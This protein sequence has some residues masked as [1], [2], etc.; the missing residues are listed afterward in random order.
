MKRSRQIPKPSAPLPGYAPHMF[1][2]TGAIVVVFWFLGIRWFDP[3]LVAQVRALPDPLP[4]GVFVSA[5]LALLVG[6]NALFVAG[7][8]AVEELK[9]VHVRHVR[10]ENEAHATK[11]QVL[12]DHQLRFAT[13]CSLGSRTVRLCMVFLVVVLGQNIAETLHRQASHPYHYGTVLFWALVVAIPVIAINLPVGELLPASYAEM[14]PHKAGLR[15]YRFIRAA[16]A[17][18]A[19][20]A[21]ILVGFS[22]A[23]TNLLAKRSDVESVI[24]P[25]EEIRTIVESAEETGDIASEER[26]LIHS[27]FEFKDTIVREIMTPRVDLD[28]VA[29]QT[30]PRAIV[31]LISE[32][33]HSRIPIYEET[34][35]QIVG[36]IHAKDLLTRFIEDPES[37]DLRKLIRPVLFVPE[38]K[39]I[40]EVLTE[41]KAHRQQLAVVQDEFGGTAGVVTI[42]DIVE[43]LVGDIVDEYDEEEHE[44]VAEGEGWLVEGKT[45]LDDVNEQIGS[46]FESDEFD[47]VGGYVFGQFGRQ[48]KPEETIDLDGF[49]F[50]VVETDGRRV[51]KLR[52]ERMEEEPNDFDLLDSP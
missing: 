34:D 30:D 44:V 13:A 8:T 33:G 43:E 23:F 49:C 6:L 16:G 51:Q 18:F 11:L 48:P 20:P 50:T 39:G 15:L 19:M 27:V 7:E 41:L 36:V 46:S 2:S 28:A 40:H 47:T 35:D 25:E 17:L 9:V 21:G 29:L 14:H 4:G 10:E 3:A 38:G 24:A 37:V 5:L 22:R 26:E 1:L 31:N 12:I 42:E 45:H 32:T 52:I